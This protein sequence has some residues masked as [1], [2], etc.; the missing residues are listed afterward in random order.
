MTRKQRLMSEGFRGSRLIRPLPAPPPR[1][2]VVYIGYGPSPS[3]GCDAVP[4][5]SPVAGSRAYPGRD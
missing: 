1:E 3:T 2:E 5:S 4:F